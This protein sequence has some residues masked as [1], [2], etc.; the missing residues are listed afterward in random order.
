VTPRL[1]LR[2][3]RL[4]GRPPGRRQVQVALAV[5]AVI[6]VLVAV[7]A[8]VGWPDWARTARPGLRF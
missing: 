3:A 8:L 1:L 6:A 5:F 7:E 2:I 4:A